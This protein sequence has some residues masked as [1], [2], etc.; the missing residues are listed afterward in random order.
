MLTPEQFSKKVDKLYNGKELNTDIK[1]K[2]DKHLH[3]I[4]NEISDYQTKN[5]SLASIKN[6]KP[7]NIAAYTLVKDTAELYKL[8]YISNVLIILGIF[9]LC[10][11]SFK[12]I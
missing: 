4:Q 9:L 11:F 3:N 1:T 7:T 2:I 10:Y 5:N 6:T 8:Q 12:K